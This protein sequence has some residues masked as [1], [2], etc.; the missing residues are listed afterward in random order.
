LNLDE[1]ANANIKQAVTTKAPAR[2]K[3]QLVRAAS[4]H[5]RSVQ[6]QPERIS[7]YFQHGSVRY[8]A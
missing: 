3:L 5:L 2:T 7:R 8:A 6:K 1:I 4:N